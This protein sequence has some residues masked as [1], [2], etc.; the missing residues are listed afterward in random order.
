MSIESKL[1]QLS[2]F[3]EKCFVN[4]SLGQL[5]SKKNAH[6]TII[7]MYRQH[8]FICREKYAQPIIIIK[9]FI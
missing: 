5:M 8:I 6:R 4:I 1:S 9:Y 3:R 7:L 2:K